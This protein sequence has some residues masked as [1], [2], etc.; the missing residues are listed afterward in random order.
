MERI[1]SIFLIFTLV[2]NQENE[3]NS[4]K[5]ESLNRLNIHYQIF[6]GII[7]ASLTFFGF[8]F[9]G[10]L[11]DITFILLFPVVIFILWC[12]HEANDYIRYNIHT[13]LIWKYENWS[14]IWWE[15]QCS[16]QK[17][18]IINFFG[19][20]TILSISIIL[21]TVYIAL[22]TTTLSN[23]QFI[24]VWIDGMMASYLIYYKF[25]ESKRK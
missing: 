10:K 13:Y 23:Q 19:S 8:I 20:L 15:S 3:Y 21:L 17:D 22:N 6:I 16:W 24:L 5:A 18:G 7:T 25:Y 12:L 9:E 14:S 4:L 11:T 1:C 2:N